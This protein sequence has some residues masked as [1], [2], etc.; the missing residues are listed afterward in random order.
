MNSKSLGNEFIPSKLNWNSLKKRPN[1]TRV[2]LQNCERRSAKKK[3]LICKKM[4]KYAFLW[5]N[6]ARWLSLRLASN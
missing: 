5:A 2:S 1:A 3:A 6:C 4:S